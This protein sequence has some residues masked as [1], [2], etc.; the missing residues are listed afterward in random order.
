MKASKL[1]LETLR[2]IAQFQQKHAYSPTLAELSERLEVSG[3][4]V[5]LRIHKL[6]KRGDLKRFGNRA[7]RITKKGRKALEKE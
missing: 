1:L 4:A 7:L 6:I 3:S 5:S 2:A